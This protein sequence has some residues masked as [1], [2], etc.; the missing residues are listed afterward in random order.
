MFVTLRGAAGEKYNC[1]VKKKN[2]TLCYSNI[3]VL[4]DRMGKKKNVQLNEISKDFTS[5]VAKEYIV[6][7]INI[8]LNDP[9]PTT[10]HTPRSLK[11]LTLPGT[12]PR[13][14]SPPRKLVFTKLGSV[15]NVVCQTE[16]F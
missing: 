6:R 10:T 5:G 7:D 13:L 14:L 4:F 12:L 11:P 3:D 9:F 16:K 15:D 8:N 1:L 2:Y